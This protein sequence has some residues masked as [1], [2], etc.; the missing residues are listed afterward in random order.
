MSKCI[1]SQS[2]SVCFL[3]KNKCFRW[4]YFNF[5]LTLAAK[6]DSVTRLERSTNSVQFFVHFASKIT[7]T[8][9]FLGS[10]RLGRVVARKI[11]HQNIKTNLALVTLIEKFHINMSPVQ[12]SFWFDFIQ[13]SL[14]AMCLDANSSINALKNG[15]Y[16]LPH[17]WQAHNIY[18]T[19]SQ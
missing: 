5:D 4:L 15:Y 7:L 11:R 3:T 2:K 12:Y 8:S 9:I 14:V 19:K 1:F 18:Q 13:S 16:L 10:S 17:Q 6:F